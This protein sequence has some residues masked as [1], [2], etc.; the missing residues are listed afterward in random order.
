M[1]GARPSSSRSEI[2]SEARPDWS[3]CPPAGGWPHCFVREARWMLHRE[4][5]SSSRRLQLPEPFGIFAP[6]QGR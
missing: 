3:Q 6:D 5:L 4:D 2:E 1:P